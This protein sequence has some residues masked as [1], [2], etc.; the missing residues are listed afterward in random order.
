MEIIVSKNCGPATFFRDLSECL[1]IGEGNETGRYISGLCF[2]MGPADTG[3]PPREP[4]GGGGGAYELGGQE[5]GTIA[6][7]QGALL[8]QQKMEGRGED[9][10]SSIPPLFV[11]PKNWMNW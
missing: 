7:P 2:P 3:R 11:A 1:L 8:S 10:R 5:A 4:E 9:K 6:G